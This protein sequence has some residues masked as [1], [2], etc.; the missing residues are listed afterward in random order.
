MKGSSLHF[1]NERE[2]DFF[3]PDFQSVVNPREMVMAFT[4]QKGEAS[5]ALS[6]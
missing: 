3:S 2:M 1:S 4:L 6:L 5:E